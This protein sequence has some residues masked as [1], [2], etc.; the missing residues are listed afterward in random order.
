MTFTATSASKPVGGRWRVAAQLTAL[1]RLI[2]MISALL[3]LILPLPVLYEIVM[4]Q[5]RHPP[6]W[7]FEMTGYAIIMIAFAASGYGLTTG[8]HFRINLLATKFPKFATPLAMLSALFELAFGVIMLIA[9]WNQ[10]YAAY[11]Q[12]LRSDTLLQIPQCWPE[13][14]FPIGG[15]AIILQSL[16]HVLVP[17]RG[18]VS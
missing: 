5:L 17:D 6:V 15:M 9:G 2:C 12:D 7:V 11:S 14:A 3:T 8:H 13:L 10:A 16:A 1:A 4:D 18:K